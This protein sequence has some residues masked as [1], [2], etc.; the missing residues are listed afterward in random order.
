M[1]W[2]EEQEQ[3]SC[4]VEGDEERREDWRGASS[5][6]DEYAR[7]IPQLD[8]DAKGE[9]EEEEETDEQVDE[10]SGEN[11]DDED[12]GEGTDTGAEN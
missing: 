1:L 11:I 6:E 2:F 4:D 9:E 3:E 12:N 5:D 8:H 10:G 7:G